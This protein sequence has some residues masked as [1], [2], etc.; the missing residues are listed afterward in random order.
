M[1]WDDIELRAFRDVLAQMSDSITYMPA[2]G[3]SV[4]VAGVYDADHQE[5]DPDTGVP[6]YSVNPLL[7]V[8][9]SD[10][11][12]GSPRPG[13]RV[14]RRGKTYRVTGSRP[15]GDVTVVLELKEGYA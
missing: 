3:D 15:E 1:R 11:P 4:S 7:T 10:L 13:D 2:Q 5:V 6:V 14:M 12:L 9:M 8:A